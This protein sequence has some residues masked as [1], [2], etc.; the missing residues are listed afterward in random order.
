MNDQ[1]IFTN[2]ET[3]EADYTQYGDCENCQE[4]YE[5][6]RLIDSLVTDIKYLE[7]EVM[8]WRQTLLKHLNSI[9]ARNLESDIFDYLVERREGTDAYDAYMKFHHYETDPLESDE[10]S[11]KLWAIKGGIDDTIVNL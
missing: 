6:Y 7:E 11:Q 1:Q 5:N 9:D 8:R 4:L 2:N 3:N 10:H